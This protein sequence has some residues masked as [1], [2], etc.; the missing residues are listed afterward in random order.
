FTYA[1]LTGR[2][3]IDKGSSGGL[4]T[5]QRGK[6]RR[7]DFSAVP[8][9]SGGDGS[10]IGAFELQPNQPVLSIARSANNVVLSWPT[11]D[12]GYTLEATS[13]LNA[14]V[15]WTTVPGTPGTVRNRS[16]ATTTAVVGKK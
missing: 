3:A 9:A 15:S 14:S 8:N 1:L 7:Y 6:P 4:T 13:N 11:S 10:D 5:D 2:P 12:T 16:S